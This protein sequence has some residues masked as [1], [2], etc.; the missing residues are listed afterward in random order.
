MEEEDFKRQ[1]KELFEETMEMK[2]NGWVWKENNYAELI[3]DVMDPHF[4]ILHC[5]YH[6]VY[7]PSFQVP[8]LFFN[9]YD[10]NNQLLKLEQVINFCKENNILISKDQELNTFTFITQGEHPVLQTI[11][12][13]VHTC[14]TKSF[15]ND[16][17]IVK[18]YIYTWL[19][20]IG[21]SV[22]LYTPIIH[23]YL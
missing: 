19:S 1:G 8:S 10:E 12:Y 22:K 11:Y 9:I 21:K 5:K 6:V 7:H 23:Q 3:Q 16:F 4:G 14:E 13:Y 18:N 15:M 20:F 2:R 17:G